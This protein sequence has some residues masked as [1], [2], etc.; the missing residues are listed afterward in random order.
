MGEF[1]LNNW[2][3]VL[4]FLASGA[5]LV[6]PDIL[7]FAGVAG[8]LGTLDATRLMNQGSTL[9]LDVRDAQDFAAGHLPRARH[10]PLADLS[11]RIS[12]IEKYKEKPVL[13]TCMK[14]T[15]SS[16][17]AKLLRRA[18]FKSV[19][20]LKGGLAAWQQASLPVEK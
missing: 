15:R 12:E 14:G 2:A 18:G 20:H 19:F 7:G 3:L 5:M 1:L 6:A 9:V 17:A 16:T 13:V 4:V 11:N 8:E 10:I